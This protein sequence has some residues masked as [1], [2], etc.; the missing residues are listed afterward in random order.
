M[1]NVFAAVFTN[2]FHRRLLTNICIHVKFILLKGSSC[3]QQNQQSVV[4]YLA[5][6]S[7]SGSK[8]FNIFHHIVGLC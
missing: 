2:E 7:A 8:T 6:L 5:L 3:K 4:N 1:Q